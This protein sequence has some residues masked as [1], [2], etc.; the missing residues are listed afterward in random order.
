[1][2]PA[3]TLVTS[4]AA[5][6]ALVA[7]AA[8]AGP[9]TGGAKLTTVL[10]GAT[11][12]PGPGD[13]DGG[14]EAKITINPGKSKICW[15]INVR[16]IDTASAAHIHSA[17]VGIAGPVVVTLSAPITNN[18]ST[19]CATVARSLADAIRKS[20]QGYYV[21]VHNA[22]YPSGALRGQLG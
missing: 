12:V 20:P 18:N 13:P 9:A 3:M 21:N 10:N 11:E 16:D 4:L 6:A 8:I 14:G 22:T 17:P 1:M 5:S 7:T 19:G 15:E 2:T